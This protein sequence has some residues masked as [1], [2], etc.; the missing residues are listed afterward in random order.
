MGLSLI[1]KLSGERSSGAMHE[2]LEGLAGFDPLL[3]E[4]AACIC[5]W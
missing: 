3:E 4:D 2:C 5:L 1:P